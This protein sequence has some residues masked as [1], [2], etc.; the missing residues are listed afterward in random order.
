MNTVP[1]LLAFFRLPTT[2]RRTPLRAK[3]PHTHKKHFN[4]IMNVGISKM[5]KRN[6]KVSVNWGNNVTSK[7]T[8]AG[9]TAQTAYTAQSSSMVA[10][11]LRQSSLLPPPGFLFSRELFFFKLLLLLYSLH[12][13]TI[14]SSIM[15][16]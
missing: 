13:L 9:S 10:T 6:S 8:T 5:C 1:A 2:D 11:K 3:C 14:L 4:S 7:A 16:L 15:V 12:P